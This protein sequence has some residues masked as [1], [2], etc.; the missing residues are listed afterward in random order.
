MLDIQG[1]AMANGAK[2]FVT[3]APSLL[4]TVNGNGDAI[5]VAALGGASLVPGLAP[6]LIFQSDVTAITGT[7][8]NLVVTLEDSVDGGVNWNTVLALT[9][10][11]TVSRQVGRIGLTAAAWP[12]NPRKLRVRWTITGTT[13]NITFSVKAVLL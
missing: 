13:P 7:G 8:A 2:P 11:T 3:L 1:I 4:R 6:F 5:D 9:A 10:Q 12:F